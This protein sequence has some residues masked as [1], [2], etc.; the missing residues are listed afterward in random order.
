LRQ[1]RQIVEDGPPKVPSYIVTFADMITLLLT[2][3]VMLLSLAEGRNPELFHIGRDAFL[4]SIRNIGLGVLLGREEVP[5]FGYRKERHFIASPDE[6]TALRTIDAEAEN[7]RRILEQVKQHAT[8][9]PLQIAAKR[10]DFSVVNVQFSPGR[11]ALNESSRRFLTGF[12]RD[13]QQDPSHKPVDLYVLGLANDEKS[14]K[15]QWLLSARRAQTVADFLR[16][17]LLA[18][19]GP[20][21]GP[22]ATWDRSKWHIRSWGAGS[23][24][25]W[26]G[27][28]S[29]ISRQSHV[30]IGVLRSSN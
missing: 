4:K 25:D 6:S 12:C 16:D 10:A 2:F 8:I 14:E 7:T 3:F 19:S 23:G 15:E 28:D 26:V 1:R 22:D 24:G 13:L 17:T 18:A 5:D 20:S 9:V 30:L 27:R 11:A 29:P 21:R